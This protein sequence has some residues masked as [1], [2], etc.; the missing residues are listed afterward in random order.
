MRYCLFLLTY[1]CAQGVEGGSN[2]ATE[3]L[4]SM[5]HD[6]VL[7]FFENHHYLQS[8]GKGHKYQETILTM[9]KADL[10]IAGAELETAAQSLESFVA[11]M[12]G[13]HPALKEKHLRKMYSV[14]FPGIKTRFIYQQHNHA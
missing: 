2:K 1:I 6:E 3:N 4:G 12:E 13:T 7:N 9:I 11:F 10:F 8:K 14:L 5:T